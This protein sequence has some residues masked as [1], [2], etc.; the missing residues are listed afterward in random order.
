M[1]TLHRLSESVRDTLD[2]LAEGWQ[3]LWHKA[4]NAI[5]RFSS[6]DAAD[7]PAHGNRWGFLSA[8]VHESGDTISIELEA[9]GLE[10]QDFDIFM[11]GA[12]LLVRG[13]KYAT[14]DTEQGHYHITERAYG[15]FERSFPLPCDVDEA[16]AKATYKNGVLMISLPKTRKAQPKKIAIN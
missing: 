9:P 12:S 3:E 6:E 13:K 2:I 11:N 15:R 5:T 14:R 7:S 1:T 8:E 4:R 10:K 16:G